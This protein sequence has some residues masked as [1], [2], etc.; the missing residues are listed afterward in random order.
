[1]PGEPAR[2]DPLLVLMRPRP[3]RTGRAEGNRWEL[4]QGRI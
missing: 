4:L 3:A 1:M 2:E